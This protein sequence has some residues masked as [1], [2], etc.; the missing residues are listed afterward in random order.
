M[1]SATRKTD[2]TTGFFAACDVIGKALAPSKLGEEL[3]NA[4][5]P[6][7]NYQLTALEALTYGEPAMAGFTLLHCAVDRLDARHGRPWADRR[8]GAGGADFV[9]PTPHRH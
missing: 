8:R 3:D 7:A 2:L 5:Q 4:A 1:Q 6:D 9:L